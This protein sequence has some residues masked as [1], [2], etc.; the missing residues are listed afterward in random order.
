MTLRKVQEGN[1]GT[2]VVYHLT[3]A[4]DEHLKAAAPGWSIYNETFVDASVAYA[5]PSDVSTLPGPLVLAGFSA[6]CQGVRAALRKGILP[7]A[8]IA[9]DGIHATKD[10]ASNA[11]NFANQI[12]PWK[13]F[14]EVCRSSPVDS[15]HPFY[16]SHTAIEPGKYLS[17]TETLPLVI[18]DIAQWLVMSMGGN[19]TFYFPP[20]LQKAD[21]KRGLVVSTPGKDA[22]AHAEQARVLLPSFLYFATSKPGDPKPNF[23]P[24]PVVKTAPPKTP[25]KPP[26]RKDDESWLDVDN[27]DHK[28]YF[29]A[30]AMLAGAGLFVVNKLRK[31][32]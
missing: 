23:P 8:V 16:L 1:K 7:F 28:G 27:G 21:D 25:T 12:E 24:A 20:E 19:Q 15:P 11:A 5:T 13:K 30:T 18:P 32:L 9:I 14:V 3:P 6:G 17:T 31:R 26:I 29:A 4:L 10:V 22:A 2:I